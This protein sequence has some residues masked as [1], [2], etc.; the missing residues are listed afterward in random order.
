[1]YDE[2]K[3]NRPK[4]QEEEMYFIDLM[5]DHVKYKLRRKKY[6]SNA[7]ILFAEED[8]NYVCF[9]IDGMAEAYVQSPQGTFVNLH[10]YKSGNFFGEIEQFYEGR[11][12]VEITA[13]T[14]CTVDMLYKNDFLDWLQHDFDAVKFLMKEVAYKL[15]INAELVE[16]VLLLTVKERLLRCLAIHSYRNNLDNLTKEQLSKEVNTPI[17]SLNRAIAECSKQGI[18]EYANKR[19]RIVNEKKVLAYFPKN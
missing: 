18:I 5:P 13:I 1:M 12:P 17:R 9:L 2:I 14:D 6:D 8:N 19:F 10:V 3:V 4:T 16:D 15:I 11:K 7:T